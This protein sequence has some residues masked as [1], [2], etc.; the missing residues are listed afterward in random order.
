MPEYLGWFHRRTR[1][2][3]LARARPACASAAVKDQNGHYRTGA[4]RDPARQTVARRKPDQSG[5][6]ANSLSERGSILNKASRGLILPSSDSADRNPHG[7]RGIAGTRT[8]SRMCT[9]PFSM[10]EFRLHSSRRRRRISAVWRF[11]LGKG[12]RCQIFKRWPAAARVQIQS[13]GGRLQR[14]SRP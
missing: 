13:I 7:R 1:M 12:V 11:Q 3:G 5:G 2:Q 14:R 6:A 10:V 8:P 4:G 9:L